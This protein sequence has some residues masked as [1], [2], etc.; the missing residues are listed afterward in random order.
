MGGVIILTPFTMAT[1][2]TRLPIGAD[3]GQCSAEVN[4][5]LRSMLS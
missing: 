2:I 4:A 3:C 5:R 1:Y